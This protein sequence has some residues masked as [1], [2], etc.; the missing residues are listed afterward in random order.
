DIE[1]VYWERRKTDWGIVTELQIPK[2]F[3]RNI[4]YIHDYHD[5]YLHDAFQ[6]INPQQIEDLVFSLLQR[7]LEKDESIREIANSFD[8]DTHMP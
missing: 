3:A 5:L 6:N 2:T 1:R 7:L 8:K 4:S